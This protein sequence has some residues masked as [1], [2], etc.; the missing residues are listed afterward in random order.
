MIKIKQMEADEISKILYTDDKDFK[1]LF[2]CSK[3]EW[4][5]FL[6]QNIENDQFFMTCVLEEN[7]LIG[8]VVAYFVPLPICQGVTV[9]Y[10]LTAGKKDNIKVLTEL[11]AW[12][13]EKGA[14]TIDILTSNPIGHSV[15]GFK[16]KA[17]NMTLKL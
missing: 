9:L 16:K 15:Y 7:K 2:D 11:K 3:G 4:C 14:K 8:Y 12:S 5:Q 17:V 10:S 13:L 1:K 6:M